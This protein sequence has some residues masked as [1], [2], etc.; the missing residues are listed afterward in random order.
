MKVFY[1]LLLAFT[2]P[3]SAINTM[4]ACG[5]GVGSLMPNVDPLTMQPPSAGL[6]LEYVKDYT[7]NQPPT[8]NAN[9]TGQTRIDVD[10]ASNGFN[11]PMVNP[12]AQNVN[13]A[14]TC[15][16]NPLPCIYSK[17]DLL[18][19]RNHPTIPD[20][21]KTLIGFS[22]SEM[23]SFSE[24]GTLNL[25]GYWVPCVLDVTSGGCLTVSRN[26]VY[27]KSGNPSTA[28][29]PVNR[30]ATGLR[31][32]TGDSTR[33]IP[34]VNN[35]GGDNP[36][37]V[38]FTCYYPATNTYGLKFKSYIP[39]C[40]QGGE[41]QFF[42]EFPSCVQ[43]NAALIDN[44]IDAESGLAKNPLGMVLDSTD[45]KSHTKFIDTVNGCGTGYARI[46]AISYNYYV[47]VTKANG[48]ADWALSSDNYVKSGNNSGYSFHADYSFGWRLDIIQEMMDGCVNASLDCHAH[49]ISPTRTLYKP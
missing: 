7:G 10:W 12:G 28:V 35:A 22:G 38:R 11:D 26:L 44:T 37:K 9:G 36:A 34:Y 45:H 30:P 29:E 14:H 20:A 16:G 47:T 21:I 23:Q 24:G 15:W 1:F 18:N 46:P 19:I 5:K 25:T 2:I 39:P 27:Y 8:F 17:T 40:D 3:A 48:T 4:P 33:T 43:T 49:L 6:T 32:I 31:M 41:L 13:H 42:I